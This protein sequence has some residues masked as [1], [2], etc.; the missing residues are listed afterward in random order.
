MN[1]SFK[2]VS[3]RFTVV[4]RSSD[5]FNTAVQAWAQRMFFALTP[6]CLQV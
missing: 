5:H 1:P 4:E 2:V 6:R 3:V